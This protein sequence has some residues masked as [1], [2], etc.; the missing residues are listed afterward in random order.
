MLVKVWG[1][2]S[3]STLLIEWKTLQPVGK[4]SLAGP[5]RIYNTKLPCDPAL[6]LQKSRKSEVEMQYNSTDCR[7]VTVARR[8]R[9]FRIH[10]HKV[11]KQSSLFTVYYLLSIV[12]D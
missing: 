11:H 6:V 1:N 3:P 5:K 12:H 4:H 7:I 8:E 9:Q 2:Q 10:Q